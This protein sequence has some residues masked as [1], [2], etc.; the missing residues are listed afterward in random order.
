M[1]FPMWGNW[2]HLEFIW[3]GLKIVRFSLVLFIFSQV[4]TLI[5]V[6]FWDGQGWVLFMVWVF[7]HFGK[8]FFLRMVF[9]FWTYFFIP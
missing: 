8:Y 6:S 7:L 2:G 4:L 1:D 5:L 3:F 9:S